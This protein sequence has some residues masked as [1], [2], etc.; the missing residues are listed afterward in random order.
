MS[1]YALV[2]ACLIAGCGSVSQSLSQGASASTPGQSAQLQVPTIV[3]A[4]MGT[5]SVYVEWQIDTA[6][7]DGVEVYVKQ[8]T[9]DSDL[10]TATYEVQLVVSSNVTQYTNAQINAWTTYSIKLRSFK[11]DQYSEFTDAYVLTGNGTLPAAASELGASQASLVTIALTWTDNSDNEDGFWVARNT[12]SGFVNLEYVSANT[13]SFTDTVSSGLSHYCYRV[14]AYNSNGLSSTSQSST[15]DVD[16][17]LPSAPSG[18]TVNDYSTSGIQ[19]AWTDNSDNERSFSI[20]RSTDGLT[21]AALGTVAADVASYQ[22]NDVHLGGIY[23]YR[24]LA[25]NYNGDSDYSNVA[26]MNYAVPAAPTL[27]ENLTASGSIRLQWSEAMDETYFTQL[28]IHSGATDQVTTYNQG[29]GGIDVAAV[30]GAMT[31]GVLRQNNLGQSAQSETIA[32]TTNNAPTANAGSDQSVYLGTTVQLDGS[33]STD[34]DGDTLTYT[35]SISTAPTASTAILSSAS[36]VNPT[37]VPIVTGNY[38]LQLLVDDG[39]ATSSI[40]TMALT[41]LYVPPTISSVSINYTTTAYPNSI[42]VPYGT[43]VDISF[44]VTQNGGLMLN[45]QFSG[46][47]SFEQISDGLVR[48]TLPSQVGAYT[49]SIL[50]SDGYTQVSAT[51]GTANVYDSSSSAVTLW[52]TAMGNYYANLQNFSAR[53][54]SEVIIPNWGWDD[55]YN[56][57]VLRSGANYKSTALDGYTSGAITIINDS[58]YVQ[59]DVL[60]NASSRSRDSNDFSQRRDIWD[61]LKLL[62]YEYVSE[63]DNQIVLRASNPNVITGMTISALSITVDKAYGDPTSIT[64]TAVSDSLSIALTLTYTHT[65]SGGTYFPTKE[66]FNEAAAI[67]GGTLT[68]QVI[69]SYSQINLNPNLSASDFSYDAW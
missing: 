40:A 49:A 60:G 53:M 45:Y 26:S 59:V 52:T 58:L 12:G 20:E 48:W 7:V 37:F 57:E 27:T 46:Q 24:I 22:D 34:A 44:S 16:T 38:I 25:S 66:T 13:T 43:A 6:N 63:D 54:K 39:Y 55:S 28:T 9:L 68:I 56:Y 14:T 1:I 18:V 50:A 29:V 42:G 51:T 5:D 4:N 17:V 65:L 30:H 8:G 69:N 33:G 67:S 21:Y 35:W 64:M 47:G 41:L 19:L 31:F 2:F 61:M 3:T 23:S 11:A 36:A 10:E 15:V 32:L 62:S